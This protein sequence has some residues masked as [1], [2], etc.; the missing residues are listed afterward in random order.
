MTQP[1]CAAISLHTF[2]DYNHAACHIYDRTGVTLGQVAELINKALHQISELKSR[3]T[4]SD[5]S[6][7]ELGFQAK[8]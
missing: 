6:S 3:S 2:Y 1:P 7:L 8:I 5:P 4:I